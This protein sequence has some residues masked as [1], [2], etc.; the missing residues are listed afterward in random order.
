VL[1]CGRAAPGACDALLFWEVW[2]Q[3]GDAVICSDCITT[4]ELTAM[5][6]GDMLEVREEEAGGYL[7]DEKVDALG[8][9]LD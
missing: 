5:V 4:G 1:R 7:I 6:Q 2:D 3:I 8:G 9:S